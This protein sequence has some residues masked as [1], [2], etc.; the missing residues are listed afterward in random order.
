MR[1]FLWTF[2]SSSL[3]LGLGESGTMS[4]HRAPLPLV[5][6]HLLRP[7][8]QPSQRSEAEDKKTRTSFSPSQ[9][10]RL[11]TD[12]VM[13]KYLTSTERIELAND[14]G[15]DWANFKHLQYRQIL[16]FHL[17]FKDIK[18]LPLMIL[19]NDNFPIILLWV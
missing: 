12:F 7:S 16:D 1:T 19:S 18:K 17:I 13:K 5:N 2:V 4:Q 11:E 9:I 6:L 8:R 10:A 3:I 14:L 15:N